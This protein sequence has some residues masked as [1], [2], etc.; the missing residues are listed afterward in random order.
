MKIFKRKP[1]QFKD[2]GYWEWRIGIFALSL[3]SRLAI[4][5][6]KKK[7]IHEYNH[8]ILGLNA[9]KSALCNEA[10][11]LK[12]E[13]V[14]RGEVYEVEVIGPKFDAKAFVKRI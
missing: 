13:P 12:H 2:L 9:S 10:C 11:G 8:L 14:S 4:I 5:A 7:N 6:I 1:E 3:L